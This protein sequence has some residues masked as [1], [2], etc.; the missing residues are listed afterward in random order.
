MLPEHTLALK[1]HYAEIEAGE[2][3]AAQNKPKKKKVKRYKKY[4]K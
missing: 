2:L 3:A 4:I 1:V